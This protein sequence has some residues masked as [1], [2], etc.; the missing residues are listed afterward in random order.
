MTWDDFKE[1]NRVYIEYNE[2]EFPEFPQNYNVAVKNRVQGTRPSNTIQ[3]CIV[4]YLLWSGYQ[5]EQINTTGIYRNGGW[6]FSG[7]TRGSA[8]ISAIIKGRSV[9]I[10]VKYGKD[11][12]SEAQIKYQERVERAGGIYWIVKNFTDFLN[13]YKTL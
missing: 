7:S 9:K 6:T 12:Q 1:L 2:R 3:N 10:E 4:K 11:K 13:K 8:D 5:A